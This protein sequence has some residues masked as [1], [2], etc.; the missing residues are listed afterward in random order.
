MKNVLIT[1]TENQ[2]KKLGKTLGSQGFTTFIEPLFTVEKIKI[3]KKPES[4]IAAIIITSSNAISAISD[5]NLPKN[6]KIFA[7][8]KQTAQKLEEVGFQNITFPK[9]NSAVALLELIT[10]THHDKTGLNLYLHGSVITLDFE[11]ELQKL[12]FN[13]QKILAYKTHEIVNFST[14]LLNFSKQKTFDQVLF[15]SSNS[16]KIFFNLAKKHNL[17]EYFASAQLLCLSEKILTEVKKIN[18]KNCATFDQFPTLKKFY[19]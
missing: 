17:L 1:R 4:Q 11:K 19:D 10:K 9:E 18:A 16:V 3:N 15:F 5:F 13:S 12:G 8:G 7:V 2:A 6:I 14:D